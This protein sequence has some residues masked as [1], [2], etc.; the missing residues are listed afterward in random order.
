MFEYV[1]SGCLAKN[2]KG[3]PKKL[4]T[5][6]ERLFSSSMCVP[7]TTF[8]PYTVYALVAF[9]SYLQE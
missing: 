7:F 5:N 9:V 8:L 3:F 6:E 4:I 1:L 2:I